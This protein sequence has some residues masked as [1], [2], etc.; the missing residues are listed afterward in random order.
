MTAAAGVVLAPDRMWASWLLVSYYAL[1]RRACRACASSPFTTRPAR[2]GASPFGACPRR[3]PGRCRSPSL[4]LAVVLHRAAAALPVDEPTA[5]SV[6]RPTA[7]SA[8]K[9][10]W[11]SRP[12]FLARAAVYAV[13][14]DGVRAGD[15]TA[16]A[17]AGR[18]R[19]SALDA[20]ERPAV[21]RVPRRVRRDVHAGELRLGDVARAAVVQH[22]LR[23]LQLRRPV[24]E[25]SRGA[26]PRGALAGAHGAASGRPDRRASARSRE[27][28]VRV[29]RRSGCTSGSASTC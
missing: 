25:R 22:D 12:F 19:R 8:F 29:Q 21:G 23:R 2:A 28:A 16:L 15:P 24:P 4:L 14:L 27:A 6:R 7:R 11:L 18:R 26:H 13:D 17:P 10:F 9:R 1:G 5:A 20:R 3:W